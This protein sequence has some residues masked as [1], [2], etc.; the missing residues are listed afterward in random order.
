MEKVFPVVFVIQRFPISGHEL[1]DLGIHVLG[2]P[3]ICHCGAP[4]LLVLVVIK[5]KTG[6]TFIEIYRIEEGLK[7]GV[8]CWTQRVAIKLHDGGFFARTPG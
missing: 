6:L 8:I 7:I 5:N 1:I 3:S 4:Y 2:C